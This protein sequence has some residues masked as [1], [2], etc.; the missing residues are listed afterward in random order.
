MAEQPLP[1]TRIDPTLRPCRFCWSQNLSV[2]FPTVPE[3][4]KHLCFVFCQTCHAIGPVKTTVETARAAW[5]LRTRRVPY[6]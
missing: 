3:P 5:N 2:S 1:G 6:L 4:D